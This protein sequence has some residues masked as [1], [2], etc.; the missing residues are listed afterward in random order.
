MDDADAL[1]TDAIA[2]EMQKAREA[3]NSGNDG[4]ARACVRRAIG[5]AVKFYERTHTP[6]DG[7]SSVDKLRSI[8]VHPAIPREVQ[9]ASLRLTTNVNMRLS[10]NF[11]FNPLLDGQVIISFLL[12]PQ[13]DTQ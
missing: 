6:F 5:I 9:Q 13:K 12:G 4:R 7:Q 1:V 8:A 2:G 3:W 10:P 11:S